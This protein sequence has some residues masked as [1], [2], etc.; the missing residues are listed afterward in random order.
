MGTVQHSEQHL[1]EIK[2]EKGMNYGKTDTQSRTKNVDEGQSGD[3]LKEIQGKYTSTH[4]NLLQPEL[5]ARQ[6]NNHTPS[7]SVLEIPVAEVKTIF[8]RQFP[9][10]EQIKHADLRELRSSVVNRE[11]KHHD[12]SGHSMFTDQSPLLSDTLISNQ[13]K[14]KQVSN[15]TSPSKTCDLQSTISTEEFKQHAGLLQIH[16]KQTASALKHFKMDENG[17][18]LVD[19]EEST[20]AEDAEIGCDNSPLQETLGECIEELQN[21]ES[22]EYIDVRTVLEMFKK[23]ELQ[24]SSAVN[25]ASP[26]GNSKTDVIAR[27]KHEITDDFNK[28]VNQ[29]DESLVEMK[30]SMAAMAK[31]MRLHEDVISYNAGVMDDVVKR[32]DNVELNNIRRMA[33][34]TGEPMSGPKKDII[35]SVAAFSNR[36]FGFSRRR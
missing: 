6:R 10:S 4:V 20:H 14:R 12:Q 27:I 9:Q 30:T 34:L 19:S 3:I 16:L 26:G 35:K 29:Q 1:Q 15:S 23:I 32:L 2:K 18:M 28:A 24:I 31:K 8:Q 7:G 5:P 25:T 21:K 36:N 33:I 22:L 11:C 13:Q 17:Q